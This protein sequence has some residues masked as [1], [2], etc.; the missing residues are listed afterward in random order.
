[1]KKRVVSSTVAALLLVAVAASAQTPPPTSPDTR[2]YIIKKGDT[3]WTI[4]KDVYQDPGK[5]PLIWNLNPQIKNP[6]VIRP[7][8]KLILGET[9]PAPEETKPVAEET[10][11]V[12]RKVPEGITSYP[13]VLPPEVTPTPSTEEKFSMEP[14][15]VY[16]I[17]KVLNSGFMTEK[18]LEDS[19]LYRSHKGGKEVP[20]RRQYRL[21]QAAQ[22][23]VCGPE[24]RRS[25]LHIQGRG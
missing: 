23:T 2:V 17:P 7:G 10:Q 25:L 3:M 21:Y 14:S 20:H 8:D 5:W 24:A 1:M 11:P 12:I 22:G 6:N 19:G 16:Y 4:S 15:D 18:E 9:K 13:E